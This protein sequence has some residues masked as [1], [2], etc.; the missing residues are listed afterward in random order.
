MYRYY[1]HHYGGSF[2]FVMIFR[3]CYKM[4]AI[5]TYTSLALKKNQ[6]KSPSICSPTPKLVQIHQ[7]RSDQESGCDIADSDPEKNSRRKK[8]NS[9]LNY[10]LSSSPFPFFWVVKMEATL[11]F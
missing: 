5:P 9:T 11:L 3:F 2:Y 8:K 7:S 1:K 4:W 6:V 10:T